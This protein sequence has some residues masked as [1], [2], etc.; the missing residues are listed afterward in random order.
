MQVTKELF[1]IEEP[2]FVNQPYSRMSVL[3][4]EGVGA[5]VYILYASLDFFLN[6]FP[7]SLFLPGFFACFPEAKKNRKTKKYT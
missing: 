7:E 1:E 5:R 6:V 2:I 3:A 4:K